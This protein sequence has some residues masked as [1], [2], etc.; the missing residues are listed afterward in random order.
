MDHGVVT[1]PGSLFFGQGQLKHGVAGRKAGQLDAEPAHLDRP[2][3]AVCDR[4]DRLV[5]YRQHHEIVVSYPDAR[6]AHRRSRIHQGQLQVCE[7]SRRNGIVEH[8]KV[9]KG[10]AHLAFN[11]Q[12]DSSIGVLGLVDRQIGKAFPQR[13]QLRR[14]AHC[15]HGASRKF[16]QRRNGGFVAARKQGLRVHRVHVREIEVGLP[17]FQQVR[18]DDPI[19]GVEQRFAQSFRPG[20]AFKADR[21]AQARFQQPNVIDVDAGQLAVFVSIAL[22][23]VIVVDREDEPRMLI[24]PGLFFRGQIIQQRWRVGFVFRCTTY[25]HS[26]GGREQRAERGRST[27]RHH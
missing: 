22:G 25:T 4:I 7:K 6:V 19:H 13:G 12:V 23:M 20:G 5:Q 17:F 11:Q 8:G 27:Q 15:R 3:I 21:D 1:K 16:V 14:V 26:A 10:A 24:E 18:V 9:A 2:A